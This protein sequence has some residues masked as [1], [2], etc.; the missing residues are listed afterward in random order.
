MIL[1]AE[2]KGMCDGRRAAVLRHWKSLQKD[3]GEDRVAIDRISH[4]SETRES[5][6]FGYRS[7]AGAIHLRC[8]DDIPRKK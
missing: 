5:V 2:E 8:S 3:I 4:F 1:A 7:N 6:R